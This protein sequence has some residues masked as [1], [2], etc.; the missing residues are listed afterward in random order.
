MAPEKRK[1]A[2]KERKDQWR[3]ALAEESDSAPPPKEPANHE[4]EPQEK[5]AVERHPENT[6]ASEPAK[7][8]GGKRKMAENGSVF[9][10]LSGLGKQ[11]LNLEGAKKFAA[12]YIDTNEKFAKNAIDVQARMTNWAKDTPLGPIFEAQQEFG[13]RLVERSA[14]AARSLWRVKEHEAHN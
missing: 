3:E 9:D 6:Q 11:M 2:K 7:R 10:N 13:R 12:W 5:A 1:R 8:F 4:P 14:D